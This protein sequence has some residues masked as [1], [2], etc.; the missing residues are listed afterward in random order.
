MA[1]DWDRLANAP[2]HPGHYDHGPAYRVMPGQS[3]LFGDNSFRSIEDQVYLTEQFKLKI[4]IYNQFFIL[5]EQ[6]WKAKLLGSY[7]VC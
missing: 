2:Q 3:Q 4:I 1:G 7:A 5:S 6:S